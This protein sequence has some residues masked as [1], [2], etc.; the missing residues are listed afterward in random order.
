MHAEHPVV[1]IKGM[2]PVLLHE[3]HGFFGHAVFDVLIRHVGVSI[4]ICKLPRRDV[5]AR[6][7]RAGMMR[8][9]DIKTLLQR[10]KGLRAEVPLAKM[11][12]G[13]ASIVQRLRQRA[14]L[15]LQSCWRIRL[16]HLLIRR[17]LFGNGRLHYNLRHV[18]VGHG[19]ARS[20]RTQ[21]GEDSRTRGRA[22]R[23]RR[24]HPCESHA[25]LRQPFDIRCL[26]KLRR[27]I[28][29]GVTPAK[30][31][32]K[33]DDHVWLICRKERRAENEDEE[34]KSFHRA[35]DLKSSARNWAGPGGRCTRT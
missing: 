1:Q 29:R 6:R 33:D 23:T 28:E 2:I 22:Q 8:H 9:I 19:D 15:G 32:S 26:I 30:I 3:S 24:I 34:T 14:V 31:I 25:A 12:R 11:P 5:T 4:K 35:A 17:A 7:T 20:C 16:H 27:A 18:A 13:I 10:R 21:P